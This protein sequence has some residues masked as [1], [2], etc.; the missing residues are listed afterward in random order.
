[1]N[2]EKHLP[3]RI[4]T[5]LLYYEEISTHSFAVFLLWTFC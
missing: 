2:R 4:K 5:Y 3:L 1:M